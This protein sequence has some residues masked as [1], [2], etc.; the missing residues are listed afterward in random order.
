MSAERNNVE[1]IEEARASKRKTIVKN[2]LEEKMIR[3]R[4][5]LSKLCANSVGFPKLLNRF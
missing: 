3:W 5:M 2:Y 4:K 1:V